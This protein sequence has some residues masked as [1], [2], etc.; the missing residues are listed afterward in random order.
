MREVL[1]LVRAPIASL[2]V[3]QR[4]VNGLV[5]HSQLLRER[6]EHPAIGAGSYADYPLAAE[7]R[8]SLCDI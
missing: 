8:D 4:G 2:S 7:E 3:V 5:V 1:K 6:D